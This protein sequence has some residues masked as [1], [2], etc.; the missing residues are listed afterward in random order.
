MKTIKS[1]LFLVLFLALAAGG[2]QLAYN[3]CLVNAHQ[4]ESAPF[5]SLFLD[6]QSKL[7]LGNTL[8]A[9]DCVFYRSG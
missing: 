2:T 7:N 3:R 4:I 1:L 5:G 9:A 6:I 8:T